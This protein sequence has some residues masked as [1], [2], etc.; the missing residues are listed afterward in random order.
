MVLL[1]KTQMN[2]LAR[3]AELLLVSWREPFR[4]L[5][6][7]IGGVRT[8]MTPHYR[9][10]CH[11]TYLLQHCRSTKSI[12]KLHAQ[13]IIGGFEQNPFVVAKLVGKYV[14]CSEP[15]METARKVFDRLLERDVF[16]WNMVIQGYAN[17][18]PFVEALKMYDRMRLSGVPANQ[19]TYPFVLKACGAMKDGKHGL[20]VHGHV[21]KCG[22]HSDLFVGNA[23]IALYSKCEEI[24]ISRRVFD[25]IPWKDSV[26]WNSMISGYTANGYP[27]EALK[28]FR[29][30]LQDHATSL[31]DHATL[32]SILPACVQ[33]SAIEVGFWIHSYTIKSSVEVDA[34]LGSALISMY[35]SCGRV[36]IARVIFDQISQKN[37][38]LWSAMMRCY[39]MHG[40]ADE[41]LQMFSQFVE[42][43]LHPDGV[44][45]LCLLSTCSHSGMVTKGLEL[46]EEMGDYGVE[47]N[48][49]H[50]ACVVDLLGRAGLLDQAVKLI[51]SIPMQAGKDAYGALLGACRIHNNIELAEEAAEKL[52]VLDPE[53]AGRYILL[54]SMYED[55][56]RWEDAARVRKLLRD[57]NVKKPTGSSSI[58]MDCTYHTFGADDESHP[59]TDQIFNTLERLDRIIEDQ[60]VMV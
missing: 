51:E 15:S 60:T 57:K 17:V 41:A 19:Y 33:A 28:L 47:K 20:I 10:S 42:S 2:G 22:L 3:Q 8:Y 31:P 6:F 30:M 54:A 56:C 18:G 9:D 5:G 7:F 44:V 48:E 55:A 46:F 1:L 50:Y 23:L 12:K 40:H 49:K 32:V 21:V 36:T 4:L 27:H 58:E 35:A 34:A 52:F 43:G 16:V 25:E 38:V 59:Y 45:F 26:S 29:A 11:Y 37:V 13:I 14:E 53:N 39:G 24:E